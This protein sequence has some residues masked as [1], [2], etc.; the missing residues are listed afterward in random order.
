MG[1]NGSLLK[2]FVYRTAAFVGLTAASTMVMA[3][4][5]LG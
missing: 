2:Y 4:P 3:L 1:S 5:Y